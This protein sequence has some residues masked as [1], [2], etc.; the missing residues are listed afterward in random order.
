LDCPGTSDPRGIALYMGQLLLIRVWL[1]HYRFGPA[2]W[3]WRSMT[4]GQWQP[5]STKV[6]TS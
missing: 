4:Y 3:F 6:P 5:I 1:S 2:E